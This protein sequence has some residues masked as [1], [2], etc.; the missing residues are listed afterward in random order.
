MAKIF[1]LASPLLRYSPEMS[2]TNCPNF[3]EPNFNYMT[4]YNVFP[5]KGLW[6]HQLTHNNLTNVYCPSL[7]FWKGGPKYNLR[8]RKPQ[9]GKYFQTVTWKWLRIFWALII[10][11]KC[12][13]LLSKD[14]LFPVWNIY[15]YIYIYTEICTCNAWVQ[16][17]MLS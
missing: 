7:E 17:S 1:T 2:A 6:T 13:S 3:V 15:H 10:F 12:R 16:Y 9:G 4:N 14:N 8:W 5:L 11:W